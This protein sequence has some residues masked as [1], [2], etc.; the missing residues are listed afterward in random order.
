M[1]LVDMKMSKEEAKKNGMAVETSPGKADNG[2]K[3]PWGLEISL[4]NDVLDKL[5]INIDTARIGK[6]YTISAVCETT[7][8]S[9]NESKNGS[10]YKTIRLQI[11]KMSVEKGKFDKYN[12][13][14]KGGPG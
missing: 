8:I 5:G 4:E 11:K 14:K 10:S 12:D 7:S 3:Y 1:K 2:P 9:E 13:L 6:E